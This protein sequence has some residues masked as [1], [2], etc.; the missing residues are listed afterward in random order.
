MCFVSK[1]FLKNY[2]A[3]YQIVPKKVQNFNIFF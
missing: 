2:F 1:K 3:Y